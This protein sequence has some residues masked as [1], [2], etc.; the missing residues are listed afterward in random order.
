M[1]ELE[2]RVIEADQRAMHAEKQV[3][4]LSTGTGSW[5]LSP[6]GYYRLAV[7]G[8]GAKRSKLSVFCE[9]VINYKVIIY[10]IYGFMMMGQMKDSKWSFK[11]LTKGVK[12]VGF[13][14]RRLNLISI[15]VSVS[16]LWI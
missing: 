10:K 13:R 15:S 11:R 16:F 8:V 4:L 5:F 9:N 14:F 6:G 7:F 12:L 2:Q 1:Q 3:L